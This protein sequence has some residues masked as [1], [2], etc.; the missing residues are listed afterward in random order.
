MNRFYV[1][2]GFTD[3]YGRAYKENA[4]FDWFETQEEAKEFIA[5]KYMGNG[6]YFKLWDLAAGD[7]NKFLRMRELEKELAELKKEF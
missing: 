1:K 2:W 4:Y 5:K 6:S 7:Y 3:D